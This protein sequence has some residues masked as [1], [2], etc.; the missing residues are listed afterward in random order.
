MKK[1]NTG[2]RRK[3]ILII[4]ED[5]NP[6]WHS[7]PA[8]VFKYLGELS[9]LVDITLVTQIRN[10]ENLEKYRPL[11]FDV[12]Y[13]DTENIA[14]PMYKL[15]NLLTGLSDKGMS[16]KVAFRYP[17]YVY[18]EWLVW[19]YFKK[20]V[21]DGVFDIVHR[22]SPMSPA[23][24]SPISKWNKYVPTIIGPVLSSPA[25]PM[26]FNHIRKKDRDWLSYFRN[27]HKILPYYRSTY[28]SA[29]A[30]L[31]GYPHTISDLPKSEL[32]KVIDFSEGGVDPTEFPISKKIY[33]DTLTILFVG[34]LVAFKCPD[35]LIHCFK[36][37]SLLKQHKLVYIGDGPEREYLEEL[38]DQH[39]LSHCVEF[40]GMITQQEVGEYMRNSEIFAF[41]SIR[42]QG[43]GVI[44]L[45]AMSGMTPVVVDYG[46]PAYRVPNGTGVRVPL[47]NE[48]ELIINFR[49][50]LEDLIKNPEKMAKYGQAAR[51]YTI[52]NYAWSVKAKNTV[53]V[54][55]WV[56]GLTKDKPEFR[57][58]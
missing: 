24:P 20:Q 4:A 38:V 34:R 25:W 33:K 3:N 14:S 56:L 55:N 37:S 31:A 28:K 23:I 13:F 40:T 21:K 43:G 26:E 10:K 52:E 32:S 46:G 12:H 35:I 22:V 15:S 16:S 39:K 9:N 2:G 5:C 7:L 36:S 18:F 8:L 41:P 48:R 57:R 53:E 17:S 54:Y 1:Q 27:I 44:T 50:A 29:A 45:A 30:I 49:T 19:R 58:G 42:E 51:K 6:E 47:T 11:N